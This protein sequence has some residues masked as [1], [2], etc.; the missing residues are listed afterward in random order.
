MINNLPAFAPTLVPTYPSV[1]GLRVFIGP[2]TVDI[3]GATSMFAGAFVNVSPLSIT[4]IYL[5]LANGVITSNT[6]GFSGNVWPIAIVTTSQ[7]EIITLADVRADVYGTTGTTGITTAADTVL[8][9]S[10]TGTLP[11]AVG[12]NYVCYCTDGAIQALP[13]PTLLAGQWATFIKRGNGAAVTIS[14]GI[15]GTRYLTNQNQYIRFQTDGLAWDVV[16]GN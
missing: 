3:S 13:D 15:S 7:T 16:G 9:P 10:G 12:T 4:Y 2:G 14:G 5:N 11:I 1:A 6:T 8:T